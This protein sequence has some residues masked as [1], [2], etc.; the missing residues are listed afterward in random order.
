MVKYKCHRLRACTRRSK[1][2]RLGLGIELG[3]GIGLGLAIGLGIGIG[4]GLGLVLGLGFS[5]RETASNIHDHTMN[6][7]QSTPVSHVYFVLHTVITDR[8]LNIAGYFIIV[9][10]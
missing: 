9:F 1:R 6:C 4:L 8:N 7:G 3:L 10:F 5:N 2:L